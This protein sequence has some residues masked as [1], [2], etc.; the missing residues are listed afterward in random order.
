[1]IILETMMLFLMNELYIKTE[2]QFYYALFGFF[3]SAQAIKWMI[4]TGNITVDSCDIKTKLTPLH[5]ACSKGQID[6]AQVLIGYS[7]DL[8]AVDTHKR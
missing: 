3:S 2:E 8:F 1:M 4:E 5:Y 6:A 7:A